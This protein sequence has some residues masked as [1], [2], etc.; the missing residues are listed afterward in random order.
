MNYL[1]HILIYKEI[2][3]KD[4]FLFGTSFKCLPIWERCELVYEM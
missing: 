3:L 1:T 4:F 2:K